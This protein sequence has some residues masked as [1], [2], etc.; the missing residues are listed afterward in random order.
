[1][2]SKV[3]PFALSY[4]AAEIDYSMIERTYGDSLFA[5]FF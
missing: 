2:P 3:N 4:F 1:M 5:L